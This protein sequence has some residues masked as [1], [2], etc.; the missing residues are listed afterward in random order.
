MWKQERKE[1]EEFLCRLQRNWIL[2]LNLGGLFSEGDEINWRYLQQP[3]CLLKQT[4]LTLL[5]YYWEFGKRV[6]T[7]SPNA[8]T[9]LANP[10]YKEIQPLKAKDEHTGA[11]VSAELLGVNSTMQQQQ[12]WPLNPNEVRVYAKRQLQHGWQAGHV[13]YYQTL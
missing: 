2:G 12:Q 9:C 6:A 1:E 4:N 7:G 10:S 5:L 3:H 13:F 8:S 11:A